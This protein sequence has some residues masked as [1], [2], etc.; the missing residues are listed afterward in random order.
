M[1]MPESTVFESANGVSTLSAIGD[2]IRMP[3]SP[4]ADGDER[5]VRP[6]LAVL[7]RIAVGPAADYYAPRFLEFERAGRSIPGWNWPAF[8]A[9]AAW[10]FYRKLWFPGVVGALMPLAGLAAFAAI[11][12]AIGDDVVLWFACAAL[13]MWILPGAV[14]AVFANALLH[15]RVRRIVADAERASGEPHDVA[16]RVGKSRPVSLPAAIALGGWGVAALIAVAVPTLQTLYDERAVR[17]EVAESLAAMRPL[18]QQI[19]DSFL[20]TGTEQSQ[21]DVA[22][23]RGDLATTLID[24]VTVSPVNGRLRLV[25]GTAVPELAGKMILLVP[26]QD[27]R[28]RVEWLCMPIDIDAKYLPAECR[29]R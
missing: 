27:A 17:V 3:W 14:A 19:E 7:F 6:A 15:R 10:A 21:Q 16:T 18:Q 5:V 24:A 2:T 28:Q 29:N 12:P 13:L 20:R 9:P 26:A 8:F 4:A 11:A 23:P 22:A 25:L 1:T